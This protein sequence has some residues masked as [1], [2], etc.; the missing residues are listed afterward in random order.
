MKKLGEWDRAWHSRI[1]MDRFVVLVFLTADEKM[2]FAREALGE[3]NE[4]VVYIDGAGCTLKVKPDTK[5]K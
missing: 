2:A 1:D 4:R 5:I 3:D